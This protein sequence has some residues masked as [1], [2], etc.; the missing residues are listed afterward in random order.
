MTPS[1]HISDAIH[2]SILT[3]D[4]QDACARLLAL[5]RVRASTTE[6]ALPTGV[7][8]RWNVPLLIG[9]AGSGKGFVCEEVARRLD[10]QVPCRRWDVG[11]WIITANRSSDTTLEQIQ[12]FIETHPAGCVVHLSEVDALAARLERNVGYYQAMASEV[13]RFLDRASMRPVRFAKRDGSE[14]PRANVL[15]V[16]AGCFPSLWGEAPSATCK[17]RI[18]GNSRIRNLWLAPPPWPSGFWNTRTC[19]PPFYVVLPPSR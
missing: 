11:S 14:E 1:G 9:P 10:P 5:A 4:Q 2:S 15:V 18:C 6:A 3:E 7:L 12:A 8:G 16:A 17:A 19:L 13:A